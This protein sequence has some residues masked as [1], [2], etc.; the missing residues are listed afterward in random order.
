M[1]SNSHYS[2]LNKT[3]AQNENILM[4]PWFNLIKL[5]PSPIIWSIYSRCSSSC[6]Y[7]YDKWIILSS[8]LLLSIF[9]TL[10]NY[11]EPWFDLISW[12]TSYYTNESE[13]S[14]RNAWCWKVSSHKNLIGTI[15]SLVESIKKFLTQIFFNFRKFKVAQN[16]FYLLE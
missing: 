8:P 10:I 1:V 4:R 12:R 9:K 15:I 16:R 2:I 13:C 5:Y 6:V 3:P 7:E 11:W 14:F